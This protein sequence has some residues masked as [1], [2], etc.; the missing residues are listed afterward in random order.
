MVGCFFKKKQ[1]NNQTD[2]KQILLFLVITLSSCHETE[3]ITH[4]RMESLDINR[5]GKMDKNNMERM[6]EMNIELID[7]LVTFFNTEFRETP[8]NLVSVMAVDPH[9]R[10]ENDTDDHGFGP[11]INAIMDKY[12]H[13]VMEFTMSQGKNSPIPRVIGGHAVFEAVFNHYRDILT[14][15]MDPSTHFFGSIYEIMM[16]DYMVMLSDNVAYISLL[17]FMNIGTNGLIGSDLKC[18]ISVMISNTFN[19]DNLEKSRKVTAFYL[20]IS[21]CIPTK[22]DTSMFVVV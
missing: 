4:T 5:L 6:V 2:M 21:D 22:G 18:Q 20:D 13:R 3:K 12:C 14:K 19:L 1:A 11:S 9:H 16:N 15:G 7:N 8:E 17:Y 10:T